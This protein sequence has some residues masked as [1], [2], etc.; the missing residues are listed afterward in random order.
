MLVYTQVGTLIS[1]SF[2]GSVRARPTKKPL[3]PLTRDAEPQLHF[4][5]GR[6]VFLR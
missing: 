4:I 2:Q 6:R 1:L 5:V 3:S